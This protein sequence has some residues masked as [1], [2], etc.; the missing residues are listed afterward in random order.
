MLYTLCIILFILY[1]IHN[2]ISVKIQSLKFL[3]K[4]KA[5]AHHWNN[6]LHLTF[7]VLFSN[8]NN[9]ISDTERAAHAG[10]INRVKWKT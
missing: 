7:A 6:E 5:S 3:L 9:E 1:I 4:S 10:A 8:W 2:I